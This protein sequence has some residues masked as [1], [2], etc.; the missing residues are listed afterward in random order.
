MNKSRVLLSLILLLTLFAMGCVSVE[1]RVRQDDGTYRTTQSL[2]WR[3]DWESLVDLDFTS[4]ECTEDHMVAATVMGVTYGWPKGKGSYV[5]VDSL[6]FESETL[7]CEVRQRT[8]TINGEV[9]GTFEEG[10]TVVIMPDG[11]VNVQRQEMQE[12]EQ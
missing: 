11:Q 2:T 10:D 9:C 12:S 4:F 7:R 8:L 6:D 3:S 1:S 5:G